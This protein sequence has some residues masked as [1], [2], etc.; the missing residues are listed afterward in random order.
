MLGQSVLWFQEQLKNK[1]FRILLVIAGI[2]LVALCVEFYLFQ[3][4]FL[5]V[6]RYVILLIALVFIAWI[7]QRS[8]RIPNRTLMILFAVR[9]VILGVEWLE[10]SDLGLALL[11]SSGV[12][13]LSGGGI[14]LLCYLISRGGIGAGDVK[15]FTVIGWFVGNGTILPIAF[16]TVVSAAFYSIVMLIRKKTSLKEEIPF[17]PFVLAGTVLSMALGM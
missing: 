2:I 8:R 1:K 13:A 11:L 5:K 17:A 15:L 10:F 4:S 9:T 3:Y 7:D 16:F 6:F 12:G 14:F